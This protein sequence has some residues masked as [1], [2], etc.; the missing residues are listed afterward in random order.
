V[1]GSTIVI[2]A[3]QEI[4]EV[5][6]IR[7]RVF[8]QK[9]TL[10]AGVKAEKVASSLDRDGL[11]TITA[12][13][14][15]SSA[16][17]LNQSIE[18]RMDRVMAPS[19]WNEPSVATTPSSTA[20]P[21]TS[22]ARDLHITR[23]GA[24]ASPADSMAKGLASDPFFDRSTLG[25]MDSFGRDSPARSLFQHS[26]ALDNTDGVSRVTTDDG[27]YKIHVNVKNYKPEELVIKTVGNSVQVEAKHMEKTPDGQSYSSRNFTQSFSLPKGVNPEAVTSSLGK[28]GQL[29]IEAPLPQPTLKQ[30]GERMVPIRHN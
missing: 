26:E 23:T 6:G 14:G 15:N 29:V 10:P 4:K 12:P 18:Q 28:D 19:S 3:K 1:E 9:F 11:L 7:T 24:T 25:A 8:E 20:S 30:S 16:S 5:G 13:R 27:T 2:T 17:S 21:K 22:G